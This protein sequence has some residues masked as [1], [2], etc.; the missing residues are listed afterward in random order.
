MKRM[1]E[2]QKKKIPDFTYS[3]LAT[4]GDGGRTLAHNLAGYMG[5][6][7]DSFDILSLGDDEGWTV[8]HEMAS[9][10][11]R[12]ASSQVLRLRNRKGW[13]V[14]HECAAR[15]AVFFKESTLALEDERGVTVDKVMATF[16]KNKQTKKAPTKGLLDKA[17]QVG[18]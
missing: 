5:R 6:K 8:A 12:F 1:D 15:G 4:R 9:K 17:N 11:N 3:E 7:F 14:A 16:K 2:E 10:G 18:K 13:S